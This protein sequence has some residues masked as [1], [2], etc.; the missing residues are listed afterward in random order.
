MLLLVFSRVGLK[1]NLLCYVYCYFPPVDFNQ[2]IYH[3]WEKY[4]CSFPIWG[5]K[6]NGGLSCPQRVDL[7]TFW[8]SK[9]GPKR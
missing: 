1:G 9:F 6:Q 8:F 3:Y 5:L 7:F 2:G 4:I